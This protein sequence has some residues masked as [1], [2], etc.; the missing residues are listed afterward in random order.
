[1][2]PLTLNRESSAIS[3]T[4]PQSRQFGRLKS[5]VATTRVDALMYADCK[6]IVDPPSTFRSPHPIFAHPARAVWRLGD[7]FVKLR[8]LWKPYFA[9]NGCRAATELAA[10]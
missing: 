4:L 10:M 8:W 1:M 9:A 2:R 6:F 7:A 5:S 3:N